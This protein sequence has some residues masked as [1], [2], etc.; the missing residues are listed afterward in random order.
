[1]KRVLQFSSLVFLSTTL[2]AHAVDLPDSGITISFTEYTSAGF[3][4]GAAA[5]SG[6]LDSDTWSLTGLSDGDL[7]FGGTATTGDF[8][9]GQSDGGSSTGGIYAF[10][11][12]AEGI[13]FGFQ[14]IGSDFTPGSAI[15]KISNA[16]GATITGIDVSYDIAVYNDKDRSNSLNFAHSADNS[17]YTNE[18]SLNYSTPTT[19][20]ISPS[21]TKISKSV[22][23]SGLSIS[24]G[25][26]YYF[27]WSS[28]DVSGSGSRDEF[29]LTSINL[30]PSTAGAVPEPAEAA[31]ILGLC[32]V[33]LTYFRRC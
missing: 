13:A 5:S 14:P 15:L 3:S 25:D 28:D 10:D 17:S 1:M 19:A 21:W 9:R 24:N 6:K 27:K 29:G 32:V 16:T 22:T 23:L 7:S 12:G 33:L 30:D 31:A 11:T 8:A 18:S 26:D 4:P 20:D 2:V